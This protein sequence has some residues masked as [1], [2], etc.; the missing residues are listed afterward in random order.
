[1]NKFTVAVDVDCVLNNL[2]EK[3]IEAYNTKYNASLTIDIFTEYDIFKCL[4]PEEAQRFIDLWKDHDLLASLTPLK[5]AQ[6]GVKQLVEHGY[7]VYIATATYH[8]NFSQK[9][10]WLKHYFGMVPEKNIICIYHKGLLKVD[11]LIDDCIDNLISSRWYE[12]I[13]FDYPWNRNIW[14]EA[15]GIRRA[16][17]WLEVIDTVNEIFEGR[18]Y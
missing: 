10:E 14:D 1:M 11:V 18:D 4:P 13:C 8:S 15:Y 3:T 7:E 17:N 16:R 5:H 12:R 6:W 2:M 9:V